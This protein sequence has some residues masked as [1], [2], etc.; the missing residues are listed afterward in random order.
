[1]RE[2]D[3]DIALSQHMLAKELVQI[4]QAYEKAIE[5]PRKERNRAI[6]DAEKRHVARVEQIRL[7]YSVRK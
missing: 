5:G 3:E 7:F 2:G 4:N 6:E 1:M